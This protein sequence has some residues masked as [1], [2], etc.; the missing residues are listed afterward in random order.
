M[1]LYNWNLQYVDEDRS[2]TQLLGL[3][4][5]DGQVFSASGTTIICV[6]HSNLQRF[7]VR[8]NRHL[9]CSPARCSL[10][11]FLRLWACY[12]LTL[13]SCSFSSFGDY[14]WSIWLLGTAINSQI[15]R[16]V[17]FTSMHG[18]G[19][20]SI[21]S[22]N[23]KAKLDCELVLAQSL[24]ESIDLLPELVRSLIQ[25]PNFWMEKVFNL[26]VSN[27]ALFSP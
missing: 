22:P 14:R 20:V 25:S 12:S 13:F 15:W 16:C 21:F 24:K 19:S 17:E 2:L 7:F 27:I 18:I 4:L 5:Q 3:L 6:F 8:P 26:H 9:L 23:T 1:Q 11:L 10:W